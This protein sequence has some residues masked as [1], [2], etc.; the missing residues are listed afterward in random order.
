MYI[1]NQPITFSIT[2]AKNAA[3]ASIATVRITKPN[4]AI[5]NAPVSATNPT[6]TTTGILTFSATPE[7]AG[8]YKIEVLDT[9]DDLLVYS[10]SI[11]VIAPSNTF[12]T[13][14]TV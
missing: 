4:K 13:Q 5:I 8:L 9:G 7:L 2:R 11:N 10:F 1:V 3:P 14:I 12:T 6:L